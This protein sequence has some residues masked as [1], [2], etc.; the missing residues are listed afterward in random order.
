M[1]KQ[2]INSCS[3]LPVRRGE[4]HFSDVTAGTACVVSVYL[5][6][7][8]RYHTRFE[9]VCIFLHFW[10]NGYDQVQNPSISK[11]S[12]AQGKQKVWRLMLKLMYHSEDRQIISRPSKTLDLATQLELTLCP[13]VRKMVPINSLK[14]FNGK[15]EL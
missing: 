11:A 5:E 2:T 8:H 13:S 14:L 3:H 7:W 9:V 15:N 12:C 10:P 1:K 6:D 4:K